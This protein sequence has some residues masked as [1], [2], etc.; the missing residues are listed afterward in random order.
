M[1]TATSNWKSMPMYLNNNFIIVEIKKKSES[2]Y[3]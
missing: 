3:W 2:E 1:Q